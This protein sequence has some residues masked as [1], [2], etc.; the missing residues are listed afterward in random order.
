[1]RDSVIDIETRLADWVVGLQTDTLPPEVAAVVQSCLVDTVGVA[2]AGTTT[3][4]Y[5][6]CRR[7]A[8]VKGSHTLIG[9]PGGC[10][11]AGAA[12]FLNAVAAHALDFDDT[13]YAG[14]VHGTAVVLPA[15]L[16][17]A[18][19]GG[20]DG[21]TVREAL[22]AGLEVEYA[23]GLAVGDRLYN[24]GHWCTSTLGV[25]GAA[26][27][28]AKALNLSRSQTADALRLA[29]NCP[30]GLRVSHGSFSKPYLCGLASRLG[31]ESAVAAEVGING[32]PG[33]FGA[34]NGFA[35]VLNDGFFEERPIEELGRRFNLVD[36]GV[37]F[38]LFPL[39]S[40]TLAAIDAALYLR[41][42]H[43]LKVEEVQAID[44]FA[45]PLVVSCLPYV[46]PN[47]QSQ[48]QFSMAFALACTLL[49]GAVEFEH[50]SAEHLRSENLMRL[51]S[52]VRLTAEPSLVGREDQLL[53]PEAARV[54]IQLSDGSRLERTVLAAKGMPSNPASTEELASKF[55]R[56]ATRAV[57]EDQAQAL[58][59]RLTE[60]R[61][62]ESV[63]QM[64]GRKVE[65]AG[66][67]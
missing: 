62:S 27:G 60:P 33:T 15:V 55:R 57:P 67:R 65:L 32:N 25:I 42:T 41:D 61:K 12:A 2:L 11:S 19:L 31:L 34:R 10:D 54:L 35:A 59:E 7:V 3:D 47:T 24:A 43:R 17:A 6:R 9:E 38:K 46:D 14:I 13:S 23:L 16:A 37:A 63:A 21:Q 49:H 44:C 45:T 5:K 48:A 53:Y 20:G 52:R 4:V 8:P 29:A 50:F 1:M 58:L 64:L 39:C 28:A 18:E 36:P 56:C 40:A 66:A 22:V 30:V 26:A 51:M